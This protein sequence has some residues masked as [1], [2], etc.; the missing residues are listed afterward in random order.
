MHSH[1]REDA[2]LDVDGVPDCVAGGVLGGVTGGPLVVD[3]GAGMRVASQVA[4]SVEVAGAGVDVEGV[5]ECNVG[6]MT[7]VISL[8]GGT[9]FSFLSSG[10]NLLSGVATSA[11]A[12][13]ACSVASSPI[14]A[15]EGRKR[16]VLRHQMPLPRRRS[17]KCREE[18]PPVAASK[19]EED[20]R[21]K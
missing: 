17:N 19:E 7:S 18:D 5:A 3:A 2:R 20:A 4:C 16:R 13:L 15:T 12:T 9:L 6:G 21:G 14:I 1:A 8:V 10:D 11:H